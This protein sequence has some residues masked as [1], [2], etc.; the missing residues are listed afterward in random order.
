MTPDPDPLYVPEDEYPRPERP[1]PAIVLALLVVV[2]VGL[3]VVGVRRDERP[4]GFRLRR[5]VRSL[6]YRLRHRSLAVS[7][8]AAMTSETAGEAGDGL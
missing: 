3:V 6:R 5:V 2:V 7:G 1:G 4:H 8:L